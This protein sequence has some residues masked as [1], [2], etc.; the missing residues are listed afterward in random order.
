MGMH[1]TLRA[2]GAPDSMPP[3]QVMVTDVSLHGVGF[4]S[5]TKLAADSLHFIEIGVGPLHL[6][7]RLRIARISKR[8]DGSYDVGAEFV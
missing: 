1:G 7:S 3:D 4:R 8:P 5:P 2:A 6:S